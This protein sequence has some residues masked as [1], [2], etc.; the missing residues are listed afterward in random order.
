MKVLEY[1]GKINPKLKLTTLLFL[2]KGNMVLLA[3]KKKGFGAGRWN[4]VGGK[5]EPGE[6]IEAAT[7]RE[8]KEE[9]GVDVKSMRKAAELE[10]YFYNENLQQNPS[11]Q[12]VSVYLAD[13][14]EGEPSE[15][16]EMAPKWYQKDSLPFESMWPDDPHWVPLVI[17]GSIVEGYFL[18]GKGDALLDH[19]VVEKGRQV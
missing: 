9:I 13:S 4:G 1:K 7:I 12:M 2:V 19:L 16:E 14:W 15:S 5:V 3:M 17:G 18:F 8:T 10:F 6:S 11:D